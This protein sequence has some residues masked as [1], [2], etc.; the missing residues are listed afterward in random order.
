M[1]WVQ[2]LFLLNGLWFLAAFVQFSLAQNNT[3]K[4]LV[5]RGAR[6]NPLVPT[7]KASVSFLGGMNLALAL[8]AL[9][10]ATGPAPFSDPDQ[11]AVLLAFFAVANGSQFVGNLPVLAQRKREGSLLWPVLSGTMLMIFVIDA[12]LAI[13][14]TIAAFYLAYG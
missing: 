6:D 5:P 2:F 11:W 3:A 9:Y 4:I 8:L 12:T 10:L 14:D 1:T 7:V 13:A